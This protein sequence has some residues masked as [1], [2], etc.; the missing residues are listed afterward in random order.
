M[1]SVSQAD[2]MER[3]R[4][5]AEDALQQLD[6]CIRYLHGIGKSSEA[7]MLSSNRRLIG[8]LLSRGR[9]QNPPSDDNRDDI[10]D[11]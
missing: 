2:D 10:D 6:W 5:A 8:S 9:S 3:Y 11:Q 1:Q 4:A 7:R